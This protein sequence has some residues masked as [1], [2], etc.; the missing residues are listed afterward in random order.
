ME[1]WGT[2]PTVKFTEARKNWKDK[3]GRFVA[4]LYC[5]V[6]KPG[7]QPIGHGES[8]I[9]H[10]MHFSHCRYNHSATSTSMSLYE[11]IYFPN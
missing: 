10:M 1:C 7:F 11:I 2:I 9:Q 5:Q 4:V 8:L 6:K 3:P